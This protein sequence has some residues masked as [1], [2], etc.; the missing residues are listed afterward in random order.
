MNDIFRL[1]LLSALGLATTLSAQVYRGDGVSSTC[2]LTDAAMPSSACPRFL[3]PVHAT[4]LPD[5][6]LL[7]IGLRRKAEEECVSSSLCGHWSCGGWQG[8]LSPDLS[9]LNPP[10]HIQLN[11]DAPPLDYPPTW[12]PCD[13]NPPPTCHTPDLWVTDSLFCGGHTLLADGRV[14]VTGGTRTVVESDP[15]KNSYIGLPYAMT[16]D[17]SAGWSNPLALVGIGGWDTAFCPLTCGPSIRY[18]EGP[19]RWYPT[20]TRMADGRV[21]VTGVT[22]VVWHRGTRYLGAPPGP[23]GSSRNLSLEL[24]D[25]ATPATP[26]TLVSAHS[27]TPA[28][29]FA[30]EYVHVFRLPYPVSR[31]GRVYELLMFGDAG[32]PIFLDDTGAYPVS[33]SEWL[34]TDD[35]RPPTPADAPNHGA[36]SVMLPLFAPHPP[37][38][39]PGSVL[40]AGG[41]DGTTQ[42]GLISVYDPTLTTGAWIV[43]S[44]LSN[45]GLHHPST[46]VLPTGEVLIIG[47]HDQTYS[48]GLY[49]E[50]VD[51]RNNFAQSVGT[52]ML[53]TIR[54]YH[55]ATVLLPDGRVFIGGGN[56]NKPGV[57]RSYE[58]ANFNYY[59]PPYWSDSTPLHIVSATPTVH[60]GGD[61]MVTVTTTRPAPQLE[62]ALVSPGSMTHSFDM[63]Q[64]Y[65]QLQPQAV[66]GSGGSFAVQL[67]APANG[68]IAPPG[69]YMLFA[70]DQSVVP[71]P[72]VCAL[73]AIVR[74]Q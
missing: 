65:I 74:I 23:C 60:H 63:N 5:G 44:P 33:A 31:G 25:P 69:H 51:P 47:G 29:I 56:G 1:T 27:T 39:Q 22:Q 21:L 6:N 37:T 73:A 43:S 19:E 53:P 40:I 13:T 18:I 52:S 68:D 45:G 2:S 49:A 16:Y 71:E 17:A 9:A 10:H 11:V 4:V 57:C 66:T 30:K 35:Q 42:H 50:F 15:T 24:Y 58:K 64:R 26:H 14:Y 38:Y 48:N 70:I 12:L 72:D 32:E 41:E 62:F 7:L 55:T 36:S 61:L 67:E 54:G 20:A 59:F 34:D 28:D 3:S 46:V 8:V